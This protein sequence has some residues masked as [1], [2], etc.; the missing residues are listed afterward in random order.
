MLETLTAEQAVHMLLNVDPW[1]AGINFMFV[2]A[3][4][5]YNVFLA[6]KREGISMPSYFYANKARSA[7]SV[8]G[9]LLAFVGVMALTPDAS[10]IA[11]FTMGVAGDVMINRAPSKSCVEHAK[12]ERNISKA[13]RQAHK[14]SE[15]GT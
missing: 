1:V 11:Y 10:M 4:F 7:T 9:T 13:V 15:A 3:G 6:S 2:T 14:K 8:L 5:F 12:E